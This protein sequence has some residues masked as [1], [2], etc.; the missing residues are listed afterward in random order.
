[1]PRL[2]F[3]AA[4]AC[5]ALYSSPAPLK[6]EGIP[7]PAGV[8]AIQFDRGPEVGRIYFTGLP[9]RRSAAFRTK[10]GADYYELCPRDYRLSRKLAAIDEEVEESSYRARRKWKV[11]AELEAEFGELLKLVGRELAVGGKMHF[12]L[13]ALNVDRLSLTP[14]GEDIVAE[15]LGANCKALI[16]DYRRNGGEVVLVVESFR[17]ETLKVAQVVEGKVHFLFFKTAATLL[18]EDEFMDAVVG[19]DV[20]D[21]LLVTRPLVLSMATGPGT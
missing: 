13:E 2:Y 11:S 17:A 8:E 18:A 9:A 16:R 10:A 21:D 15:N 20:V 12:E 5:F 6:A 1:M 19:V 7:L 14:F 3:L 4:L